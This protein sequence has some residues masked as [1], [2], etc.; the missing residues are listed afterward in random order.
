MTHEQRT[1]RMA[2]LVANDEPGDEAA[3]EFAKLQCGP[4]ADEQDFL[5]LIEEL[6]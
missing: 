4:D 6:L 1:D 5:D 2:E 3:L